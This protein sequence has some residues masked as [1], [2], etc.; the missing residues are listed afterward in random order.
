MAGG[1]VPFE[2]VLNSDQPGSKGQRGLRVEAA[3]I[4][5]IKRG[6]PELQL[7]FTNHQAPCALHDWAIQLNKNSFGLAP[8]Q[9][10]QLPKLGQGAQEVA[11]LPLVPN[12]LSSNTPP[13]LPL[14]VQ[15]AVK[16]NVDIFYF[17]VPFDLSAVL[18]EGG[19]IDKEPFRAKWQALGEQGALMAAWTGAQQ[20]GDGVSKLLRAS[21]CYL[22]A[23]RA[24]DTFEAL[25]F[26]C[27]TANNMVVLSEVSL[28][29]NGP[30][31]KIAV[32][33]DAAALVP[34]YQSLLCKILGLTPKQRTS[35]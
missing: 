14:M 16:T 33:T 15:V 23:E 34:L 26:S 18:V 27:T 25:Y 8:G 3:L 12:Q 4:R 10:L 17:S 6:V 35:G 1:S 30:G 13:V 21:N 24:A 32:R 11:V 7:R 31:V 28:Q 9:A 29:K 5:N 20:S 19:P 22:V 2:Q